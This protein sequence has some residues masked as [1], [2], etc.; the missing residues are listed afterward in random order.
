MF[1][2]EASYCTSLPRQ[3]ANESQ[4]DKSV[5]RVSDTP[6]LLQPALQKLLVVVYYTPSIANVLRY[7]IECAGS[8]PINEVKR[9]RRDR[10][11]D[12]FIFVAHQSAECSVGGGSFA[13]DVPR[14]DV[15]VLI[16]VIASTH[17]PSSFL[18]YLRQRDGVFSDSINCETD[19]A[20][21]INNIQCA[22]QCMM[23]TPDRKVCR[24]RPLTGCARAIGREQ[25]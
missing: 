12:G 22:Q 2:N 11:L 13:C 5:K 1:R 24:E 9:R 4:S 25:P 21:A 23:S 20:S 10:Y 3:L 7:H 8:R 17:H 14:S 6:L 19:G 15:T 16:T 18:L